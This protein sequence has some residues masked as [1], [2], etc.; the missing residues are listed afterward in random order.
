M[1][2]RATAQRT[3][4]FL[5]KVQVSIDRCQKAHRKG[6][7]SPFALGAA[8]SMTLRKEIKMRPRHGMQRRV[9]DTTV[10]STGKISGFAGS[11]FCSAGILSSAAVRSGIAA[12]FVSSRAASRL[13]SRVTTKHESVHDRATAQRTAFWPKY[14]F[15]LTAAKRPTV[16]GR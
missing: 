6:T 5:A 2:D 10:E 7:V 14:K 13:H 15:Q 4:F 1:H 16:K 12:P 3:A 9:E 11:G 8:P